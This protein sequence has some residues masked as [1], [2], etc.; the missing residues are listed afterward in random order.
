[1]NAVIQAGG[2][3][4]KVIPGQKIVVDR[5]ADEVGKIVEYPALLVVDEKAVKLGKE[6]ETVKV[7]AK[8]VEHKKGEKIRI[9]RFKAKSR[10]ARRRGFRPYQTVLQI[11]SIGKQISV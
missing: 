2:N 5:L 9:L 11:E 1:M 3:Q 6:A 4:Y 8:I 7:K 10:Y